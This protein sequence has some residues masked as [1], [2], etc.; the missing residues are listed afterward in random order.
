M[1]FKISTTTSP[2]FFTSFRL[3]SKLQNEMHVCKIVFKITQRSF[4]FVRN[5]LVPQPNVMY[6]FTVHTAMGPEL[7]LHVRRQFVSERDYM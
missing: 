5:F 2:N 7:A 6:K 4:L 1:F 3:F